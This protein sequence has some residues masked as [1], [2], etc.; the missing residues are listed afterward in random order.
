MS[1]AVAAIDPS[2]KSDGNYWS[3]Y[4]RLLR[5]AKPYTGAFMIGVLGMILFAATQ[6]G[7]VYLVQT[8]LKGAFVNK[9]PRVEWIVPIGEIGRAHV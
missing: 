4:L 5:Y 9:D 3:I 7:L 2:P 1:A 8:F 6:S